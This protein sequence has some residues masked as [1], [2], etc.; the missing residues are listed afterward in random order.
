MFALLPHLAGVTLLP[1]SRSVAI[2]APPPRRTASA[3]LSLQDEQTESIKACAI[4][5]VSG[6]L[7]AVPAFVVS[8][9]ANSAAEWQFS[10]GMLAPELALFGAVYR[11]TVRSDESMP[12]RQGVVGAFAL[13]RAFASVQFSSTFSPDYMATSLFVTAGEGAFAF[14]CA[15]AAIEFVFALPPGSSA[16]V[17]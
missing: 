9:A 2:A 8:E 6:S 10:V 11:C 4:A 5:T 17:G 14:G 7:A 16:L 12:L 1:N 13:C 3:R 15:A